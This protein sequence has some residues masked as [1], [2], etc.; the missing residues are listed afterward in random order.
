MTKRGEKTRNLNTLTEAA[1]WGKI[2]S[3]L[4]RLSIYWKPA[5]EA[6]KR[7]RR[8]YKGKGRQKY[9][10]QCASCKKWFKGTDINIDHKV[11]VGTLRS[12]DDL[13]GF[14][15]RLFIENPDGYQ[16][17]CKNKRNKM[18]KLIHEGCHEKKGKKK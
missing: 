4:R 3:A 6:K 8:N 2:R 12:S 1:F 11:E 17:L 7:A 18:G 9:E 10:Y 13:K 15:D 14:V 16:I 5:Q